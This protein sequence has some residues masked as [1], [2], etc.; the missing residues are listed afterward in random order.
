MLPIETCTPLTL[1]KLCIDNIDLRYAADTY[2]RLIRFSALESLIIGGCVGADAVF[3]QM[4][5]PHLRPARL[6]KIRWFHEETSEPHAIEAFEGLLESITGLEI[7]HV[8]INNLRG[9]P[10][11]SAVAHHG[12]T[13]KC[14]SI[15]SRME[16]HTTLYERDGFDE[17]CNN[18][19]ELQ[20]LSMTF[21]PTSVSDANRNTEFNTY[22]VTL[23]LTFSSF[24]LQETDLTKQRTRDLRASYASMFLNWISFLHSVYF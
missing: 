2:M 7:L 10:G 17:I 23:L 20:Q 21:P 6:K 5:K 8:D 3:S 12:K 4:S 16:S 19:T 18:C 11:A 1:K 9:L 24:L 22:L 14:L 13:L 15:R